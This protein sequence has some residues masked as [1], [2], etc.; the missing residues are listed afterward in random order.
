MLEELLDYRDFAYLSLVVT[1]K[2]GLLEKV[3]EG[4]SI[5]TVKLS[6][7]IIIGSITASRIFS[8]ILGPS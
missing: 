1:K 6:K 5:S 2:L 4:Y 7:A 8:T 3:L